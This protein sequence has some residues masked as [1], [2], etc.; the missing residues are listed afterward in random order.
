MI[1]EASM[2]AKFDD[3]AKRKGWTEQQMDG[4]IDG[5]MDKET[6]WLICDGCIQK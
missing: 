6:F 4:R 3:F 1:G 2:N 5:L